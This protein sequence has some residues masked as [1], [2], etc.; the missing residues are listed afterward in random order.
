MS[1]ARLYTDFLNWHRNPEWYQTGSYITKEYLHFLGKTGMNIPGR[2]HSLKD[3]TWESKCFTDILPFS[4]VKKMPQLHQAMRWLHQWQ[5]DF[6]R[7]QTSSNSFCLSPQGQGQR[8][9]ELMV[10]PLYVLLFFVKNLLCMFRAFLRFFFRFIFNESEG[11][12]MILRK[13]LNL[14]KSRAANQ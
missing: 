2:S 3:C 9:S 4:H 10:T 13:K 5:L 12:N 7:S 1:R 11:R 6:H 8:H 14:R